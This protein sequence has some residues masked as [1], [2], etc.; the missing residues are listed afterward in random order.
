MRLRQSITDA[1][2]RNPRVFS[3]ASLPLAAIHSLARFIAPHSPEQLEWSGQLQTIASKKFAR[4]RIGYLEK[5]ELD[6][7]LKAPDQPRAYRE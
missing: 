4:P 3:Q 5:D 7:L 1:P 2:I 6:A